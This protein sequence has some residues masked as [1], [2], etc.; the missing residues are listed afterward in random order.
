[1]ANW[2][3][4]CVGRWSWRR[5]TAAGLFV[6]EMNP[7]TG[8]LTPLA[9]AGD[10]SELVDMDHG[11][12]ILK[13]AAKGLSG[14]AGQFCNFTVRN[15]SIEMWFQLTSMPADNWFI[16]KSNGI[17]RGYFGGIQANGIITFRTYD[18]AWRN[19]TSALNGIQLGRRHHVV[20]SKTGTNIYIYVDGEDLTAGP[21]VHGPVVDASADTL[22]VYSI[23]GG[24]RLRG[25]CGPKRIWNGRALSI[26]DARILN[27]LG[28][29]RT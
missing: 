6:N 20:I 1:M 26:S 12:G 11:Q 8:D 27:Q 21:A 5:R 17:D 25:Y 14:G 13:D 15:F 29:N 16:Q 22:Y 2:E 7:G 18:T 24:N 19:T 10:D 4:N 28:P 23:A 9:F 3:Q